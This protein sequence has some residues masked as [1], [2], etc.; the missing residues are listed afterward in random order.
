[1]KR[2]LLLA[3]LCIV[4]V[5]GMRAQRW[6]AQ[7]PTDGDFYLYN[8]G[9]GSFLSCGA[10][11]GT[12]ALIDNGALSFTLT[13]NGAGA[14]TLYTTSTF[15]YGEPNSAQLQSS[16]Y[17]D[18]SATA[19]TW[20]FTP[21]SGLENT[22][23]ML[24]AAGT[25]LVAPSDGTK[26]ILLNADAPATNYGYWKLI[27]T[28][29]LFPETASAENPT[30]ITC[31][32]GDANFESSNVTM[33]GMWSMTSD[34][35]NLCGGDDPNCCAE[36]FHAAFTLSQAITVP[37]GYYRVRAQAAIRID[38]G[39][40]D[41]PYPVVYASSGTSEVTTNFKTIT[42]SE[43]S[44]G[45]MS[46][47]FTSGL[48]WTD[49]TDIILV[50]NGSLT[51]GAKGT[52]TNHWCCWDNFQLEYLGPIPTPGTYYL[53]NVGSGLYFGG[54][55][56]WGSK[57]TLIEV[58]IEIDLTST[59]A[60]DTK[61]SN[62]GDNHYF[63]GE[64]CDGAATSM[65]FGKVS[66]GIYVIKKLDEDGYI[67]YDGTNRAIV[68]NLADASSPNAQ[69]R[70]VTKAQRLATLSAA[71]SGNGVDAT[72]LLKNYRF[73]RNDTRMSNWTI[74]DVSNADGAATYTN[75]GVWAADAT[76]A[77]NKGSCAEYA[78]EFYN[79]EF[80]LYQTV[81]GLPN[82]VY[83]LSVAGFGRGGRTIFYA[84]TT[85]ATMAHT[86]GGRTYVQAKAAILDGTMT[87]ESTGRF[88][89]TDGNLTFGIKRTSADGNDWAVFN[90]FRLTYYGPYVS[91]EPNVSVNIS[92]DTP[93]RD[94][95]NWTAS[96]TPTYDA[97]YNNAEYWNKSAATLS[98]TLSNLPAGYYTL[99][100][101]ALTRTDMV[102]TL[103]AEGESVNI[104]TVG[105]GTVN[106]RGGAATWFDEGN[107]VNTLTFHH[108]ADGDLTFTLTADATTGDHWLVWRNFSLFYHGAYVLSKERERLADKVEEAEGLYASLPTAAEAALRTVV[109]AQ[110]ITYATGKGYSDAADA[111]DAAITT[112]RAIIESYDRFLSVKANVL[113]LRNQTTKFTDR[114]GS[115]AFTTLEGAAST[116]QTAV[117]AATTTGAIETAIT[118]LRQAASTFAGSVT[119]VTGQY[120]DLTDAMLYNAAMRETG[121]LSLWTIASNT[122]PAYP[123]YNGRCSEFWGANFDFYQIAPQLP[124]GNY[125]IEV[126]A[127]HRAGTYN[128]YLYAKVGETV[129]KV[130]V[131]P[132][133]NGE[134]TMAEAANSF[135][136]GL[137]LNSLVFSLDAASN[138][139]IGFKNEDGGET[140]KWTIFRDFKIKYFGND[141][142]AVY[143]DAYEEALDAAEAALDNPTYSNVGGTDRSNLYTAVNT[144]YPKSV[145]ET[146]ETQLKFETA[147]TDLTN[148]TNA[149]KNGVGTWNTYTTARALA[150]R[151]KEKADAI[152]TTIYTTLY[153]SDPIP[154]ATGGANTATTGASDMT[155]TLNALTQAIKV[156]EYNYV[157][158]N[159]V[160]AIELGEWTTT[161]AITRTGQHWDGTGSGGSAYD[162]QNVGYGSTADWHTSYT[163]DINL[164]TG[165]YVFQVAGRCSPYATLTLK[166][167][168]GET[169]LG[170]INDF[171]RN[172][173]SGLGINTSGET[174]FHAA[175]EDHVY[176]NGG[177][178]RGWE[179]RY[180][181]F[182]VS[183]GEGEATI[184]ISVN[185]DM[186]S[187]QTHQYVGFCNYQVR[188]APS[189]AA[190]T[191]KYNQAFAAAEA[192]RDNS[193]YA[194]VQGKDRADLL[195]AIAADKGS[196]IASIDEATSNLRT[197]TTAFTSGVASWNSYVANRAL[198]VAEKDKADA[199]STTIYTTLY[200]SDPIPA[201]T[202]STTASDAAT[203]ATTF[204]TMT[205]A[206]KVGEY[207]YVI[208]NYTTSVM[209]GDWEQE[210]GTVFNYGGQ[211][212]SGDASRGYWEQTSANYG[213]ASWNISFHQS[214]T[215]PAGDYIF[216]VAGRHAAGGDVTMSLN[217]TDITDEEDP[218]LL[219]TVNDF[220]A[221]ATGKGIDT[222]G[223][224][225]F[226]EG[227]YSNSNNGNGWEWRYVPFTLAAE[228]E[229]KVAVTAS[230]TATGKWI[231]F[232]DYEVRAIPNV[233]IST[234]AYNQ[235]KDAAE[236][237]RD[238]A[239]Y[240]NV[241]GT[242]R[243]N[244]LAAIAAE[245]GS[246]PG[247]IDAAT[248]NL[249]AK[250]TTFTSGVASWNA[251]AAS[252]VPVP[253][254]ELPYAST[255]KWSTLTTA[256]NATVNT[257]AEA[258]SQAT[259]INNANR[260]YV[261]SN[262]MA[263]GVNGAVD[264][265]SKLVQ[266]NAPATYG[267][268]SGWTR[269]LNI[270]SGDETTM[271]VR[272][273]EQFTQGNS[274]AG[275]PY[276][277]GGDLWGTTAYTMD[278]Y[279]NVNLNP[280]RY[281]LTV[282]SRASAGLKTFQLYADGN[283]QNLEKVGAEGNVFGGGWNDQS[284]EFSFEG[285]PKDV[286][287]GLNIEMDATHNWWSANRFRLVQLEAYLTLD[288]SVAYTPERCA[289]RVTLNR[290]FN[291]NW[292]TFV[293]PFDI[294]NTTLRAKF[295]DDVQ[296]SE[297]SHNEKWAISFEPMETPAIT[298]NTPVLMKTSTD[299]SSFTFS[300]VIIKEDNIEE[301]N[302]I[303]HVNP[304]MG[305]DVIGHYGGKVSIPGDD[306]DYLYY[307]IASNKMKHSTGKQTIKGYRAYFKAEDS[308][309][310]KAFFEGLDFGD[311]ETGIKLANSEKK[312]DVIYNLSGQ[313]VSKTQ[314]GGI[315]IVNGKKV[316][317]K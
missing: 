292:A 203:L 152:S 173:D 310:V 159:Y 126:Y 62:G 19:T 314:K 73:N 94:V 269:D 291:S 82:G 180:V 146:G 149:F 98:K 279:Q 170:S 250:T 313:R 67:G 66:D 83:E 12:Y 198:T 69:W 56:N 3:M 244:L 111:V 251:Y 80:H 60:L 93:I 38:N 260:L 226:G 186:T 150:V 2:K 40:N 307:Y 166:V 87:R 233:A 89:I 160:D 44:M 49:Y 216:K 155:T 315:Y 272:N 301:G 55:T 123:K 102:A 274:T 195:T 153:G 237:A 293:V 172:G 15:S 204:D 268:I 239:T 132:I 43:N 33:K 263:E 220:P 129:N 147:T 120:L 258:A 65:Y 302:P 235:A 289:A 75:M 161:N 165:D 108:A 106:G 54:G 275:G 316:L 116:Q 257:A 217:V 265:T 154:T 266:P 197:T 110:N 306:G 174:D 79:T 103:S 158:D 35:Q 209:L 128:T 48:Y 281:L 182:S 119:L 114:S 295:G 22:Y 92:N 253:I 47:S 125:N 156:G 31:L 17:V 105:S 104:A 227:T 284:L 231:S 224:A 90:N 215:L 206:L 18:Q 142:L 256:V 162:E 267:E 214:I 32:I 202:S 187:G 23:T 221:S 242:D 10:A 191:V 309:D 285:D 228:T 283:T 208:A 241:Q 280:G 178:G 53:Q 249:R 163:Q 299:A 52:S 27:N 297:F 45:A 247:E 141:A 311:L 30:N 85:E 193:T 175:D 88:Q 131:L 68:N 113:A 286:K 51:V 148:L 169:L 137:Y 183:A 1:M 234:I 298:A 240:T 57:A 288:E 212:W 130:Q 117:D 20:T 308:A 287:L 304:D 230:A 164:P 140:D 171:P 13:S 24:N 262:A 312:E 97:V 5:L 133:A 229:V 259:A 136:A 124:A 58:G 290:T 134:N 61:I 157:E 29:N 107:G 252:K 81:T 6:T 8:V 95:T 192:A 71:N 207:D 264:I 14:Y 34:N 305:I 16:G 277:D 167:E 143:R 118:N 121:G 222:S 176:A 145:V 109:D 223:A 122:N 115:S 138:V 225:N 232:C 64:Y 303:I 246:T 294:D 139:N 42:Q 271:D 185:G 91:T 86:S 39:A 50:T 84:N 25:Y 218:D 9:T 190:S 243:S 200:S 26:S 41:D 210:G 213:S 188:T 101:V 78:P 151:E 205:K 4:S 112:A 270:T 28:A 7:A 238:N 76:D 282:T 59:A 181:P 201:Y 36:S 199:I 37:N 300:N 273:N 96:Q 219:G 248:E 194:N 99:T 278:F 211:H 168:E 196:T 63:S 100:A 21:V 77:N 11:W 177:V 296:V 74:E 144:T 261:E 135:D 255:S 317:V 179:W 236:A 70:L 127:F 46:T 245:K 184:T 189:V 72:F 254:S 276:Y